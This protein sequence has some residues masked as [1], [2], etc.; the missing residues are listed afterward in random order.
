LTEKPF[1]AFLRSY[2]P[3]VQEESFLDKYLI[4]MGI[5][6]SSKHGDVWPGWE[7]YIEAL[8]RHFERLDTFL[9]GEDESIVN[10]IYGNVQSGKTGHLLAN[11]CW[12]RD[13]GFHLAVVLTGSVTDLGEQTVERLRTKLPPNTAHLIS[14]PTESRLNSGNL[15]S[16]I[17]FLVESRNL[18]SGKPLPVITLIKSSVRLK[19]VRSIIN[20]INNNLKV[21]LKIIILDDEADQASVDA[22]QSSKTSF[23]EDVVLSENTSTRVS[24]HN[25]INEIRDEIDGK[26]IY[27]AYTATP[28]A[29]MHGDLYGP[30]QPRICSVVPAGDKYV[31]IGDLV[32]TKNSLVQLDEVASG[33]SSE[34]NLIAMEQCLVQFLIYC[35]LHK[36]W[37]NIFH[38]KGLKEGYSC[39]ENSLQFLIHPSGLTNDHMQFKEAMD[40]CL[41]DFRTFMHDINLRDDFVT[42]YFEPAYKVLLSKLNVTECEF[43]TTDEQKIDCWDYVINL[44]DSTD[45]LKV[46]LVNSKERENLNGQGGKQPLVPVMPEQ[47]QIADA[48]ILIGGEILGRGLSIPHLTTTLFLRNPK[49]PLFDTAVQ[50]MRFCGYRRDYLRFI[51]VFAPGDI[52][53]DYQDAVK[54]DEPFRQRAQKWDITNRDLIKNPPIMRFIAPVTT[55]FR[56]TRNSVLSG[57]IEVRNSSSKSGLFNIGQIASPIRLVS[58]LDLTLHLV[59]NSVFLETY[60]NAGTRMAIFKLDTKDA[61]LLLNRFKVSPSESSDLRSLSELLEYNESERGLAN[62]ELLFA[63]D[64]SILGYSSGEELFR[65]MVISKEL[66]FRTLSGG[67]DPEVWKECKE[68]GDMLSVQAKSIVGDS[69]RNVHKQYSDS[70]LLQIRLYRL[71]VDPE[72]SI[73]KY[74]YEGYENGVGVGVSLIGWIPDSQEEFYINREACIS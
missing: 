73:K 13:N 40:Q 66:P 30:L 26:L 38:G 20:A 52:I 48:W 28:Q 8:E 27:L 1:G 22:S 61:Q 43:I 17:S 34:E 5:K 21:P 69:E 59:A 51:Q 25:R 32:R 39:E 57:Q 33:V 54:I 37:P 2:V 9:D 47:W 36:K 3:S 53:L 63:V 58:N 10:L 62:L 7:I 44:I 24:I 60:V 42:Q 4:D 72:T 65:S 55:R 14:A 50:Q 49:N 41:R 31:S 6:H 19:A 68:D 56:P 64:E 23:I 18:D 67:I 11:I 46:K 74:N 71:L 29:L 45:R 70:I 35:W 15:S 12:A 16:E